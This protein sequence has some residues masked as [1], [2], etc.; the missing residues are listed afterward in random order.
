MG[1]NDQADCRQ[2]GD[3]ESDLD[4]LT[5]FSEYRKTVLNE[6]IALRESNKKILEEV[7]ELHKEI[8]EVKITQ[9][10]LKEKH[11]YI[12]AAIGFIVSLI[13][14]AVQNYFFK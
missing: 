12:S 7:A 13:T 11:Y 4:F 3:G 2:D 14:Y 10:V 8:Q 5:L 9:A 1:Q 6:I